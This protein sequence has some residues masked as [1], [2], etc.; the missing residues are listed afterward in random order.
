MPELEL[1]RALWTVIR[2]RVEA[3]RAEPERGDIVQTVI[4]IA[5]LAAAAIAITA[6]L[7][8]K[9]RSKAESVQTE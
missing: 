1:L 4:I 6:I 8:A 5:A 2:A 3:L 9:A 7:V